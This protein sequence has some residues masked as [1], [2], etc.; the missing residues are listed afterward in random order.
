MSNIDIAKHT[1]V[2]R[3]KNKNWNGVPYCLWADIFDQAVPDAPI[4]AFGLDNPATVIFPERKAFMA[5]GY[6]TEIIMD[7]AIEFLHKQNPEWEYLDP[8]ISEE[9][10]ITFPK[11]LIYYNQ[12]ASEQI[13]NR[14]FLAEAC[15]I[16]KSPY[17]FVA[18]MNQEAILATAY[19]RDSSIIFQFVALQLF[20][21]GHS[22]STRISPGVFMADNTGR[23]VGGVAYSHALYEDI[24]RSVEEDDDTNIDVNIIER[25]SKKI[26]EIVAYGS[27]PEILF[28]NIWITM[29]EKGNELKLEARSENNYMLDVDLILVI[30]KMPSIDLFEDEID[31][32]K[33][34][35]NGSNND[36]KDFGA[37]GMI[38]LKIIYKKSTS[39]LI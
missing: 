6:T 7:K 33:M 3:L 32:L 17:V 1:I 26:L 13:L 37:N 28:Y 19:T 24:M 8:E 14:N 36:V 18:A 25:E 29:M 12:Y 23:L 9:E 21:F 39:L 35:I 31:D 22:P 27:N 20:R 4:V 15:D 5:S 16:L 34:K 10:K 38:N 30:D 11:T 2:P